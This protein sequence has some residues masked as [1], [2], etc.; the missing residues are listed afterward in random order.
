MSTKS[1]KLN[2]EAL[3]AWLEQT[4]KDAKY[5]RKPLQQIYYENGVQ[6]HIKDRREA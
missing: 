3:E 2:Y 1:Q 4:R 5:K 6:T